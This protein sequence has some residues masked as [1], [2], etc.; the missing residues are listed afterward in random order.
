MIKMRPLSNLYRVFAR[1]ISPECVRV[2]RPSP[3]WSV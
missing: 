3:R 1:E 2:D